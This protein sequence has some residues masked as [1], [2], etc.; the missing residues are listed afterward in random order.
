VKVFAIHDGRYVQTQTSNIWPPRVL[1][2]VVFGSEGDVVNGTGTRRALAS[3]AVLDIDLAGIVAVA[4]LKTGFGELNE[5]QIVGEE[6]RGARGV[7][8]V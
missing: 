4:D 3:F 6:R 8:E 5:W 2:T 1:R 7:A